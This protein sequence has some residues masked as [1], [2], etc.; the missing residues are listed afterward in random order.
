MVNIQWYTYIHFLLVI[1]CML[2]FLSIHFQSFNIVV[3]KVYPLL[4]TY[5][6]ILFLLTYLE[7]FVVISYRHHLPGR[8]MAL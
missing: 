6:L 3:H 5:S 4:A 2:I 7:I 8:E 1:V